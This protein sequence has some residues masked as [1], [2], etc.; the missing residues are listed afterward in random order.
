MILKSGQDTL[1]VAATFLLALLGCMLVV[2]GM[3]WGPWAG[4]DSVAYFEAARNLANGDGLVQR[5]ASGDRITLT[6]HPPFY[7]IL[8]T[9]FHILI[10]DNI[11]AA[12]I[13]NVLLFGSLILLVGLFFGFCTNQSRMSALICILVLTSPLLLSIF[14]GAMSEPLFLV[15]SVA[16]LVVIVAYLET[17]R[18]WLLVLSALLAGLSLI[19]RYIGVS[20]IAAGSLGLLII[21]QDRFLKRL[22]KS[23][24]FSAIAL[25]PFLIWT[26]YLF[27]SGESLWM[28]DFQRPDLWNRL[29]PYR[30]EFL[31][32][33][34]RWMK[35]DSFFPTLDYDGKLNVFL[36]L[37][38]VVVLIF[39]TAIGIRYRGFKFHN[40][41]RITSLKF[42]TIFLVFSFTFVVLTALAFLFSTQVQ[43][44]PNERIISPFL[45]G[46]LLGFSSGVLFLLDLFPNTRLLNIA[47]SILL[48]A[49]SAYQIVSGISYL[50]NLHE[51]GT[52]YTSEEWQTSELMSEVKRLH[53]GTPLISNE[54]DAILLYANR[55]AYRIPEIVQKKKYEQFSSFG[56]DPEDRIQ[57]IFRTEGAA[58]VLFDTVY[59]QLNDFYYHQA[60]ERLEAFTKDLYLY[61]KTDDGEIYF[62]TSP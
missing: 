33:V 40:I 14:T 1:F 41:V 58:L 7:P 44:L 16:S 21:Y 25:F 45:L 17:N 12:K 59:W 38:I 8:L 11:L 35:F 32:I 4:S 15:L 28:F 22:E 24:V 53:D 30:I 19:T 31:E 50:Q 57:Q 46:I 3:Q 52:G 49:L 27:T 5:Q 43:P 34:W 13:T 61:M 23:I 42:T 20:A 9:A 62:Y 2:Y 39:V 26:I 54:A 55:P 56:E 37:I 51:K 36:G 60:D 47:I 10:K 18:T 6:L 29:S 48:L